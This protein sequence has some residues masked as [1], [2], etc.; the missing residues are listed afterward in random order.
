M[1]G[2]TEQS[3]L[4][5]SQLDRQREHW[6]QTLESRPQMFGEAPSWAAIQAAERFKHEGT[7][8]LLEL[9]GGQG[10]DTI[11]FAGQGIHLSVLDYSHPGLT[12][13]QQRAATLG[14]QQKVDVVQHDVRQPL[15][16]ADDTFDACYSHMLFCMALTTTELEAL[17]KEVCR[18]LKPGGLHVYTVRHKR[19]AHYG[20]GAH[21]GEDMYEVGGFIVH[22]FDREKVQR[23]AQGYE[24]VS[25]QEFEEGN[26]P[27]R[28]FL[29]TQRKM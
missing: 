19:D 12:A 24:L 11:F 28:L 27:R 16:F 7:V 15:P 14:L 22:F 20:M 25:M 26:L 6:Q 13:I 29:V 8:R 9:G 4:D 23:L 5:H 18:V 17:S 10:R 21:R 3:G 2:K 1:H